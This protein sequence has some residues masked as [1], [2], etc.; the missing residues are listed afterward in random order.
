MTT[1]ITEDDLYRTST[2][3]RL[4]T[5]TPTTLA[6]RR[7][8]TH[9]AAL[10][11]LPLRPNHSNPQPFTQTDSLALLRRYTSQLH[12]TATHLSLPGPLTATACQY[13]AR[14]YL[15]YS[16]LTY[17][18]RQIYK[19]CLWLACK[20]HGTH[21][22]LNDFLRRIGSEGEKD[23][24]LAAEFLVLGGLGWV[25]EVKGPGQ[26]LKG[27]LVEAVG[28][29]EEGELE[30]LGMPGEGARTVWKGEGAAGGRVRAAYAAAKGVLERPALLTD[31]WFLFSPAQMV[32]AGL[33]VADGVLAGFC[34][35][36]KLGPLDV[37]VSER[38]LEAVRACAEMLAGFDEGEVLGRE[39]REEVEARLEMWRDPGT[40]DLVGRFGAG[41]AAGGQGE[42]AEE[43]RK[44]MKKEAREKSRREGDELFGPGL[45]RKG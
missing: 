44:E 15:T 1:P 43:R 9:T 22:G 6:A 2:Q 17:P 12:T 27:W 30:G 33:M 11:R 14:F 42:E 4:W 28:L 37:E 26:G 39:G 5:F 8:Q 29:A 41:K 38:V 23:V 10:A 20:V 34:L 35:E 7:T 36:R 16:P 24:V 32:F 40:R 3:H 45:A 18:P 19:T 21:L 25:V 13:L 31:V